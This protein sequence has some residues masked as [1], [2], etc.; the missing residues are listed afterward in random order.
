MPGTE[1]SAWASAEY[2]EYLTI[3]FRYCL[4]GAR[5]HTGRDKETK[6]GKER[7]RKK[8]ECRCLAPERQARLSA[9]AAL[10]VRKM[11]GPFSTP[12]SPTFASATFDLCRLC[13]LL[14]AARTL[15]T[16]DT[17]AMPLGYVGII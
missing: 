10:R 13:T 14:N 2:W 1:P 5:S 17:R 15:T 12:F 16:L 4:Q 11:F 9:P 7:K 8:I 3:I 6:R